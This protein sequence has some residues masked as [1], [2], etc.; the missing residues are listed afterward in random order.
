MS[1]TE[2]A[3]QEDWDEYGRTRLA[4]IRKDPDKFIIDQR[5]SHRAA[6]EDISRIVGDVSG[7]N[8]LDVGCGR[9]EFSIWLALQGANVSGLDIGPSLIE[10]AKA[11]AQVNGVSC[12]FRAG[13]IR[14]LP[15]K[16][17]AFDFV[18]SIAVLHHLSEPDVITSLKECDRVL[19]RG[20][21]FLAYEPVEDSKAF[22]FMQNVIPV[23]RP[24]DTEYRPSILMRKRWAEYLKERDDRPMTSCE[25]INAGTGVFNNAEMFHYGLFVRLVRII[26]Y[27]HKRWLYG[28]DRWLLYRLP[29]LKKICQSVL[30][31]Y[32]K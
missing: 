26:G 15:F 8:I 14:R 27:G 22:D 17:E 7:K 13:D 2:I 30:I 23:G 29:F 31:K 25:L 19:K 10:A 11:Q 9:G 1:Y 18:L 12:D 32:I 24:G 4:E 3:T 20:G 28:F 6:F 21:L 16:D 5:P